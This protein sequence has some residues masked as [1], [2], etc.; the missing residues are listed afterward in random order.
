MKRK[1]DLILHN[2]FLRGN[3]DTV[4]KIGINKGKIV[5]ISEDSVGVADLEL[6]AEKNLVTES[7]VNP[8]LHLDKVFTLE[9]LDELALKQYHGGQ[10]AAAAEAIELASRVKT[11]YDRSW[12]MDNAR[13][14]LRWA[15]VNGNTHIR[16]FADVDNKAKLEG[17]LALLELREEF[18]NIVDIQVVAFPQDGVVKEPGADLLVHEAMTMGA[19]VV[20]GIPWIE[21]SAT[22]AQSHIDAMFAIATKFDVPV[23]MLVDDAGDP[24]LRTLEMLAMTTKSVGWNERVLAH[25]A[26]AMALYPDNYH[27]RVA[28]LLRDNRIGLVTDPHTGPLHA[29]VRELLEQ[30]VLV[31]LGQDDISDAYYPYGRNNMLEVA[32]L[33]SHLLWMTTQADMEILYDMI[34]VNAARAIG[35]SNHKLE[36]GSTASLVVLDVPHIVDALRFH[37][38][39]KYVI[40][41]GRVIANDG[42]LI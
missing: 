21:Y 25:H 20:G 23:S 19:D 17:V 14:V 30:D 9:R 5:E 13:T 11:E 15:A 29:R 24:A 10:M 12:I 36:I 16:A 1:L 27:S 31:C 28:K 8:H 32:F 40:N 39:P 26:R 22:D 6:D 38:A 37:R 3:P 33:V 18:S 4:H 34:T 42:V 41:H 2:V 7:F 35:L